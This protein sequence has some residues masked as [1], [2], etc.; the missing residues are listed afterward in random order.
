MRRPIVPP[1][2]NGVGSV[3]D[4]P[5]KDK[6]QEGIIYRTPKGLFKWTGSGWQS[7]E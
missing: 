1:V 6:R 2:A 7:S 4:A 3:P 5:S